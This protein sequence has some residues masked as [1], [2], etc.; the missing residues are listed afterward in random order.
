MKI[1]TEWTVLQIFF[2]GIKYNCTNKWS[3]SSG[4]YSS[5]FAS[6][7]R[8]QRLNYKEKSTNPQTLNK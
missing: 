6:T 1:K 8:R 7:S 3:V 5:S 2:F 4:K